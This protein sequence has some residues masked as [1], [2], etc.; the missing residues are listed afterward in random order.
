MN[1][2]GTVTASNLCLAPAYQSAISENFGKNYWNFAGA[3]LHNSVYHPSIW[4]GNYDLYLWKI[5]ILIKPRLVMPDIT[6]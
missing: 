4:H 6:S 3:I 2:P 1:F 5:R